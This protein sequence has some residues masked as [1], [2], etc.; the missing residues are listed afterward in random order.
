[1]ARLAALCPAASSVEWY[2]F[3]LY[4]TASAVVLGPPLSRPSRSGGAVGQAVGAVPDEREA[5]PESP[6]PRVPDRAPTRARRRTDGLAM[7]PLL[8]QALS[9]QLAQLAADDDRAPDGWWF[10]ADE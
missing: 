2:D 9:S 5:P 4:A 7:V 1:M 10:T 3:F 6:P 8:A